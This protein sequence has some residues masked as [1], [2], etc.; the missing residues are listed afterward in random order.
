M[1]K[2][3]FVEKKA[4]FQVKSESLVRELQHN[5]GL[6]TLKSIRIVQVYDVFDLAEDL[7]APAEKH[8]FSEQVT[9]HVLDEAAVQA[10]LAN[11]AFFAI[12]SLPG[13]FDQR[14]ASSQEALLLLGSSSDVTV[15][16]AQLY[17][18]NKDTDATELEAVKNYLLNP[19]DSRF[20][21]I[22]TGIAKQEF[23]RPS[24]GWPWKWMI[25]SLSKTTSSQSGACRL[26]RSSRFWTLTGLTTA[27]TRLLR[28][29]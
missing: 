9:D 29:S 28:R 13:Q 17:L 22:T 26:R 20:K 8:I 5:L 3:I 24:K 21:D 7:F 18:V 6:S 23:S 4:D 15:N 16:T 1:D 19:V 11:Y 12:E 10:D 27:V 25:C 2:R 14:A